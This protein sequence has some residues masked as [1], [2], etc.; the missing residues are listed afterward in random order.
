MSAGFYIR[1]T[2]IMCFFESFVFRNTNILIDGLKIVIMAKKQKGG[3]NIALHFCTVLEFVPPL[4]QFLFVIAVAF[5]VV[6]ACTVH[7]VNHMKVTF[8]KL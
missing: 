3:I 6:L 7:I 1:N 2:L 4:T 8:A 5:M